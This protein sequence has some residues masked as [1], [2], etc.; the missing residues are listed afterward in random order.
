MGLPASILTLVHAQSFSRIRFFVTPWTV[1]RQAPLSWDFLGVGCRFL[2]QGIS[3]TQ[4]W[5]LQTD[6]LMSEPPGAPAAKRAVPN[7]GQCVSRIACDSLEGGRG[8]REGGWGGG[9]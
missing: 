1:V 7:T 8:S 2:L 5:N 4:G 6:S 3:P 9:V